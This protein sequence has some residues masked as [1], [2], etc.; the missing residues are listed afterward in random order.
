[1]SVTGYSKRKRILSGK[2]WSKGGGKIAKRK[3]GG[4][5]GGGEGGERAAT[6]VEQGQEIQF[7]P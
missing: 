4:V 7:H 3:I 2:D 1:M 6:I 5:K